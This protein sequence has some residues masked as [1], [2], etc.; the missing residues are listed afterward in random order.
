MC[1]CGDSGAFVGSILS[2]TRLEEAED[3]RFGGLECIRRSGLNWKAT[4]AGGVEERGGEDVEVSGVEW[5][6]AIVETMSRIAPA[7]AGY[8]EVKGMRRLSMVV[9]RHEVGQ[10]RTRKAHRDWQGK[11]GLGQRYLVR[12]KVVEVESLRM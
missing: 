6:I 3:R 4:A 9:R 2:R 8:C 1:E 5:G 10:V 11:Q 12:A 7:V